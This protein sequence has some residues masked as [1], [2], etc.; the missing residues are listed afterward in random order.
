ILTATVGDGDVPTF[1][2]VERKIQTRLTH[3]ESMSELLAA[4][5]SLTIDPRVLEVEKTQEDIEVQEL[6]AQKRAE[7]GLSVPKAIPAPA[8]GG[9]A[10]PPR[11]L[12]GPRGGF[13]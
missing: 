6:L 3:A 10:W 1:A 8:P 13:A 4:Q 5:A 12:E 2:E 11:R 9:D 7:L